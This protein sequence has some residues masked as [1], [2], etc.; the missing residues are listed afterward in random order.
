MAIELHVGG[1]DW[2]R[3]VEPMWATHLPTNIIKI[4]LA[5]GSF[6]NQYHC[7]LVQYQ[8]HNYNKHSSWHLHDHSTNMFDASFN[9]EMLHAIDLHLVRIV[10]EENP[11]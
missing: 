4:M 9:V 11:C 5:H 1:M 7:L 6:V 10:V 8:P 2:I 3:D